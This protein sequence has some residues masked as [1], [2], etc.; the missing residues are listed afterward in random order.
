MRH[1]AAEHS[2]FGPSLPQSLKVADGAGDFKRLWQAFMTA[3]LVLGTVLALMQTALYLSGSTHS[4]AMLALCFAYFAGTVATRLF[5][6]PRPLGG[7]FTRSWGG[8]IGIDVLVFS[9]LQWLQGGNLNYAPLFALPVLV[10]SVLGSLQLALGTAAGVTMILLAGAAWAQLQS[11]LGGTA[12]LVQIGVSGLGYFAIA[13][14]ANQLATRLANEGRRARQ[15]QVA[16]NIQREVNELVI[17]A[18]PEGVMI[19]DHGDIVRAANPAARAMLGTD[20]HRQAHA[21]DL[22]AEHAWQPLLALARLSLRSGGN[23]EAEVSLSSESSG[24]LKMLARTRLAAP[25]G[26]GEDSLCVLF[27]QDQRQ[28][29]ARL[30][31]EKMASMGRMSTAVAHEIRNPLAAISQAN[32]LLA[33]ELTDPA[34]LRLTGMVSQNALRL[35][36]IV[37]DI[38]NVARARVASHAENGT[39]FGLSESVQHITREWAGQHPKTALILMDV[40][41]LAHAVRFDLEHLR[42]VLINLLD[43][44]LRYASASP[45]AIQIA[46]RYSQEQAW[47]SVWSDGARMDQTVERHLF[48]PFFSSESRSSGMGLYIARELCERHG[49]TLTYQRTMRLR[50][51]RKME[52]NEFLL[53][54]QLLPSA[55]QIDVAP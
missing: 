16:A 22:K 14:L 34:Q 37:D 41:P 5:L 13:F 36:K 55:A 47:V 25:Q 1:D 35:E 48:E 19:V 9:A 40:D 38:L 26:I 43:N 46:V 10:A 29:E 2:W 52:G 30:R 50:E 6:R 11:E 8:L 3:R 33:E 23:Q 42:Q 20:L 24:P 21:F 7:A 15:S 51:G 27:L 39:L 44:A 4:E 28:A 32:A 18:L 54:L 31:T 17:D 53:A 49:G 12:S 45:E